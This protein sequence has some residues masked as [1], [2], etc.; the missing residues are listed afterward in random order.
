[1]NNPFENNVSTNFQINETN[2]TNFTDADWLQMK[3]RTTENSTL[4][5]NN[6]KTVVARSFINTY[7]PDVHHFTFNILKYLRCIIF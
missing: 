7:I 5:L 4:F 3:D 2:L 1:M 6:Q